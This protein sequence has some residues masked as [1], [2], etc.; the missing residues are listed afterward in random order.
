MLNGKVYKKI[1]IAPNQTGTIKINPKDFRESGRIIN[2]IDNTTG[3]KCI[4]FYKN[5]NRIFKILYV[6]ETKNKE[7]SFLN[8][9]FPEVDV[10]KKQLYSIKKTKTQD[11]LDI[12]EGYKIQVEEN[13]GKT[14]IYKTIYKY[15]NESKDADKI[16]V[17]EQNL[18]FLIRILNDPEFRLIR[19]FRR[20]H[21]FSFKLKDGSIELIND[22]PKIKTV[23]NV[24]LPEFN[25]TKYTYILSEPEKAFNYIQNNEPLLLAFNNILKNSPKLAKRGQLK[26]LSNM[27]QLE[28]VYN[29]II[30]LLL[31]LIENSMAEV[32]LP[33]M[34]LKEIVGPPPDFN[35]TKTY[36]IPL[37]E[38]N[39]AIKSYNKY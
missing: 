18:F 32:S 25:N 39:E 17:Y 14:A 8:Y 29:S 30:D 31:A 24:K 6:A 28:G 37:N 3:K 13:S 38:V 23:P 2:E 10:W 20:E 34:G 33:N 36:I 11:I 4:S 19:E 5:M 1:V 15:E 9:I 7:N 21:I 12:E 16:K 22:E 27:D 35:E 26:Y